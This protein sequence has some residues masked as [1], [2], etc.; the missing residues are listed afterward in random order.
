[1]RGQLIDSPGYLANYVLAAIA[2]AALR[3]RIRELRGDWSTG[4]AGWYGFVS[5]RLLRFG[6][7]RVPADLIAELLGGPLTV[8]PVLDDLR[9]A[10]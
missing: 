8:Q 1:V 4:D 5:E 7:S 10:G 3:G 9:R 2:A 6:G